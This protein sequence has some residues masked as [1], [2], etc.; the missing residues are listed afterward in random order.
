MTTEAMKPPAIT[1]PAITPPAMTNERR[2]T[3]DTDWPTDNPFFHGPFAPWTEE[4]AAYDLEIEGEIP[5]DLRG[6]LFRSSSN[7]RF[8]PRSFERYHWFE[9]DGMVAAIYVR[10]G[11]ASYRARWVETDSFK[12]EVERGEAIY[13]GFVNG[14]SWGFVPDGAPK[15]K[16]VA[17]THMGMFGDHLLVFF[18]GG[19]PYAMDPE[20]LDTRGE[21]NFHGG[22]DTLCTA[23]FKYDPA[24]GDL[25]FFAAVGKVVTW[26]RADAA[27]GRVIDSRSFDVDTPVMMHDFAV[28]ENYAA[29]FVSPLQLRFD[30][31]AQGKPGVVWNEHELPGETQLILL[32]RRTHE[33]TRHEIGDASLPSHFYNAFEIGDEVVVRG[34]RSTQFGTPI[35]RLNSPMQPHEFLGAESYPWE[36]RVDTVTG[37]VKSTQV[38][39]INGDLPRI[40][41]RLTGRENRFG[42]YMAEKITR[43]D[44]LR[45]TDQF[46]GA[47]APLAGPSEPVFVPRENSTGEDD[48]YLLSLW[49]HPLTRLTEV[50]VHDAANPS[51]QPLTRIKLPVR[52][53]NGFHGS[54]A[55]AA[56]LDGIAAE[57]AADDIR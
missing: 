41:D 39:D 36:W 12:V 9:G 11:K 2:R 23:H 40:D 10:D 28:S 1:P 55:D 49:W 21:W 26:Y 57:T 20:T 25:L 45:G 48:G 8:Q 46:Y 37:A 16:N 32:D 3:V 35:D 29:F 50:L 5:A 43:H 44:H 47:P 34:H 18:E 56:V 14:G 53:P 6:A 19:L 27:T 30:Y 13:S 24:T 4:S 7:P 31:V 54:W 15:F 38:N 51:D 33:I 42:Y 22:I 17:N 52:I